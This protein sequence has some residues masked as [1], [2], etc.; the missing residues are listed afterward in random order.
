MYNYQAS[1]LKPRIVA[2]KIDPDTKGKKSWKPVKSKEPDCASY[3]YGKSK[4]FVSKRSFTHQ[5]AMPKDSG[6]THKNETF[7][8]Q[9]TKAKKFVPG[10]G[11]YHP[12]VDYVAI[13]YGRKRC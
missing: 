7:T 13:P 4:D 11:S 6:H 5:F 12:K 3:E 10:V 2:V 9:A 1:R 8:T